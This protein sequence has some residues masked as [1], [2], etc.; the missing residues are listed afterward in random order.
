MMCYT[1][2]SDSLIDNQTVKG[3]TKD[4]NT[5]VNEPYFLKTN[6]AFNHHTL[7]YALKDTFYS[8]YFVSLFKLILKLSETVAAL[9]LSKTDFFRKVDKVLQVFYFFMSTIYSYA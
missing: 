3:L 9:V 6:L 5:T 7:Y 2:V 1:A 4:H 8:C